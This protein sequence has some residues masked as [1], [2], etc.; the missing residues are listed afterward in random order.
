MTGDRRLLTPSFA[1]S[2]AIHLV[3]LAVV[4]AVWGPSVQRSVADIIPVRLL[5]VAGDGRAAAAAPPKAEAPRPPQRR[6]ARAPA[7]PPAPPR[8]VAEPEKRV[9]EPVPAAPAPD[10]GPKAVGSAVSL[11]SPAPAEQ[12]GAVGDARGVADALAGLGRGDALGAGSGGA[13]S[14]P[15]YRV[16][17]KPQY[18]PLARERGNEGTVVLRVR[19]LPDGTAGEVT[20]TRSS[21]H[22]ILDAAALRAVK[23]WL[24]APATRNGIPVPAWIAVPI[25]FSLAS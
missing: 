10:P 15:G 7:A 16:N 25:R 21:G 2:L 19:V 20:V 6:V 18:P 8:P 4:G 9:P 22:E 11:A 14:A 24:F 1:A 13:L 23:A 5:P 12:G 3:L 17:P